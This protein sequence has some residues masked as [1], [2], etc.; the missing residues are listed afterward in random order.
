MHR[1]II[2]KG[3]DAISEFLGL[4]SVVYR[5]YFLG[6]VIVVAAVEILGVIVI[7]LL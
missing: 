2:E 1:N 6:G 4:D 3:L 5:R 7:S